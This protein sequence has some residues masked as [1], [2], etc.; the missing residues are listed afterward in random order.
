MK[1]VVGEDASCI[2]ELIYGRSVRVDKASELLQGEDE[3]V[4]VPQRT[5]RWSGHVPIHGIPFFK[6]GYCIFFKGWH[7]T[8]LVSPALGTD[9][10]SFLCWSKI[11]SNCLYS[12]SIFR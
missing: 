4:V 1:W 3:G 7:E 11:P 9:L 6:E 2:C 5:W 8:K 10:G 12:C